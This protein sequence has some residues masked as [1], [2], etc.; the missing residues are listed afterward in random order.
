MAS[1]TTNYSLVKPAYSDTADIGT[2]NDNMDAIDRALQALA[3][4]EA[5]VSKNNTH[6]VIS[7]GQYVY[8]HNH[9]TLPEG[10]Y[11]ANSS[12]VANAALSLSN[13]TAVSGGGLN[14]LK[15]QL[16]NF[17]NISGNDIMAGEDLNNLTESGVYSVSSALNSP[18]STGAY[19]TVVV[20]RYST[21]NLVTQI[22]MSVT[23][24]K[25]FFRRRHEG[26]WYGWNQMYLAET[27]YASLNLSGV[28][29]NYVSGYGTFGLLPFLNA[30][31]YDISVTSATVTGS[32]TD[33]KENLTIT[34]K[35]QGFGVTCSTD[36]SGKLL[37]VTC[38]LSKS[39]T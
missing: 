7:A 33:I 16:G 31:M 8:V 3:A 6:G 5:I 21:S 11:T 2:I 36:I 10:L 18:F 13:L 9:G 32:P 23:S 28:M 12:I 35:K 1:N 26:T 30:D 19:V 39:G 29:G 4:G 37:N 25:I 24:N 20:V 17:T 34:K 22:C 38:N 14:A 27:S 15:G